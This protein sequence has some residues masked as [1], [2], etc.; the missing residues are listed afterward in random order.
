MAI[1]HES[2]Y[3]SGDLSKINFSDYIHRL[4]LHLFSMYRTEMNRVKSRIEVGDVFLDINRA[5]PCGLIINELVSNALKYAF[6]DGKKGE[7]TVK[8]KVDENDKYTLVVKDTGIG[9]PQDLDFRH[10]ETLGMQLVTDLT[11]QLDG[12]VELKRE[13]GT[14]F[15]IVF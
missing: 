11:A 12:S 6:P 2:L 1:V 15:K 8:M 13:K 9:F 14:E 3:R 5:I 4:T 7:I 10:T